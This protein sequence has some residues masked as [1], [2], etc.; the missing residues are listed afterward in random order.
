M[1][2]VLDGEVLELF[3][4]LAG[5]RVADRRLS[6]RSPT[7]SSAISASSAWACTRMAALRS[8]AA[9]GA[10]GL[11]WAWC[12]CSVALWALTLTVPVERAPQVVVADGLV[13]GDGATVLGAD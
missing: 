1:R 10:R 7:S 9:A 4:L 13:R 2:A 12:R 6:G 8:P 11:V 3:V 5:H